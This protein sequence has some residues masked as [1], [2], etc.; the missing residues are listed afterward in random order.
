M[1]TLKRLALTYREIF[2]KARVRSLCVAFVLLALALIFQSY[3]SAYSIRNSEHFVGDI[4]LDNFPAVDLNAIIVEGALIAIAASIGILLVNPRYLTFA[5]KASALLIAVRAFFVAATHLGIYPNQIVPDPSGWAD[6]L[7][8]SLGLE[9]GYFFSAHTALPFLMGLIFWD[10]R[11]LRFI[12]FGA[13]LLFGF[14]VLL[15]KVHYSIDVFAAPFITY[16]LFKAAQYMFLED[17]R[18]ITG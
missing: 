6:S 9:G 11:P 16:S 1:T 15:A 10:K 18:L 5:L 7:Y 2:T 3:A 13:S 8:L 17:Y 12:Y 4:F 14:S